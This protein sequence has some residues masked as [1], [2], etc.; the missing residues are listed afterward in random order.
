L[1]IVR[2]I[3]GCPDA[4]L[5]EKRP[6]GKAK[7]IWLLGDVIIKATGKETGGKYSV[8]EINA[9]SLSGPPPHYHTNLEEAFYVLEGEFSFQYNEWPLILLLVHL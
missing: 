2:V 9:P 1:I 8:W 3:R 7:K 4:Y 5:T 6:A